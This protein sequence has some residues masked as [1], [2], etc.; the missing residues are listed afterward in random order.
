[1]KVRGSTMAAVVTWLCH[2]TGT[3]TR[4][5]SRVC[6]PYSVMKVYGSSSV[7]ALPCGKTRRP[8]P[9]WHLSAQQSEGSVIGLLEGKLTMGTDSLPI[10]KAPWVWPLF[11]EVQLTLLIA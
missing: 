5:A 1:M 4:T 9:T 7:M 11:L 8:W 10:L 3:T 2:G 6:C